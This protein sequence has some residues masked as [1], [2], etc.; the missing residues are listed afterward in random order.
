MDFDTKIAQNA[1]PIYERIEDAARS[2]SSINVD[3]TG[4]RVDGESFWLW[5]FVNRQVAFFRIEEG[6]DYSAAS[7]LR[8]IRV[9]R[10]LRI[11]MSVFLGLPAEHKSQG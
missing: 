9:H 7:K 10:C 5:N 6:S 1:E 3:E 2:S 11:W 8:Q 4:F